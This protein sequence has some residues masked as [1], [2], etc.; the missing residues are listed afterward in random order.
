MTDRD[1]IEA[2]ARDLYDRFSWM[3]SPDEKGYHYGRL[4]HAHVEA[5]L[6]AV[7]MLHRL[8]ASQPGDDER[9]ACDV[10]VAPGTTIRSGVQLSTL[11]SAVRLRSTWPGGPFKFPR[12]E[13][14]CICGK[15][16][17]VRE[18]SEGGGPDGAQ[19]TDGRWTC[20]AEHFDIA[21]SED[22]AHLCERGRFRNWRDCPDHNGAGPAAAVPEGWQL[23]PRDP[24]PEMLSNI[25]TAITKKYGAAGWSRTVE[26]GS[27]VWRLMLAAAPKAGDGKGG[28]A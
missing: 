13:Q 18:Q 27:A 12:R 11:V 19:L 15:R 6:S 17:D 16:F 7:D 24:T 4:P 20:S 10:K 25:G 26:V 28:D 22:M 3:I 2:M 8:A 14:C 1:K 23:V 21:T 5:V 9:I